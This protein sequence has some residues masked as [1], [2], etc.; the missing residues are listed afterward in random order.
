MQRSDR[1]VYSAVI[2]GQVGRRPAVLLNRLCGNSGPRLPRPCL[3]PPAFSPNQHMDIRRRVTFAFVY[4]RTGLRLKPVKISH[5]G[6][7]VATAT[8]PL[9]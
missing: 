2:G 5:S 7:R 9:Q 4:P 1:G 6:L 8:S 3:T